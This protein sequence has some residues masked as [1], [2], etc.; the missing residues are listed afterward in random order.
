[1]ETVGGA[2]RGP[3][4]P[5]RLPHEPRESPSQ[6]RLQSGPGTD[7]GLRPRRR[8][9]PPTG[10][11]VA[12]GAAL[13]VSGQP[14]ARQ[15]A[16]PPHWLRRRSAPGRLALATWKPDEYFVTMKPTGNRRAAKAASFNGRVSERMAITPSVF[17][18]PCRHP[19]RY[20]AKTLGDYAR[21]DICTAHEVDAT[22]SLGGLER[23]TALLSVSALG[24]WGKSCSCGFQTPSGLFTSVTLVMRVSASSFRTRA[25]FLCVRTDGWVI[26]TTAL[27]RADTLPTFYGSVLMHHLVYGRVVA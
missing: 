6:L 4:I 13:Q 17:P 7:G 3:P 18:P 12:P 8:R 14:W 10:G 11:P 2:A 24:V 25:R 23:V 5:E 21:H 9:P 26:F 22:A 15:A 16:G 1:M 27:L 20:S 19:F